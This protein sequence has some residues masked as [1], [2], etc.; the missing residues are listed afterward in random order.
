MF[1]Y[2]DM[3]LSKEYKWDRYGKNPTYLSDTIAL[4]KRVA[5]A[6]G[7]TILTAEKHK[8]GL[9]FGLTITT[10]CGCYTGAFLSDEWLDLT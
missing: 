1:I 8:N 5:E 9:A 2:F 4:A 6:N 3:N 7:I 10:A